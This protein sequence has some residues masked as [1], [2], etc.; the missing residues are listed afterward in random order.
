QVRFPSDVRCETWV[1]RGT[2]VTPFY[3]PMLAKLIVSAPTREDALAKM[4]RALAAPALA[5]VETNLDY[6]REALSQPAF[7]AGGFST[8]FL[9]GVD[10]QP[11]AFEVVDPGIAAAGREFRGGGGV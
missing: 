10:Y 3:D 6:L 1:G 5:G 7:H 11:R 4:K 9:S 8:D 2:E